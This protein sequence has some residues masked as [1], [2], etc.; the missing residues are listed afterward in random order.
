MASRVSDTKFLYRNV[1]RPVQLGL[2]DAT[3]AFRTL[4]AMEDRIRRAASANKHRR[5]LS[6]ER[7]AATYEQLMLPVLWNGLNMYADDRKLEK[8]ISG[9]KG[10]VWKAEWNGEIE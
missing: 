8:A 3:T 4:Q 10:I 9:F 1:S 7:S 2:R 6:K 5:S